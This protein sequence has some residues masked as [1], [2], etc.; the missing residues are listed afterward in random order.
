[1]GKCQYKEF[2]TI[3]GKFPY[4]INTTSRYK[5][6]SVLEG[7]LV[8]GG[9]FD[10]NNV[11]CTY[12][13]D[14]FL[15]NFNLKWNDLQN[16]FIASFGIEEYY[17][18]QFVLTQESKE[19]LENNPILEQWRQE[20]K[21]KE[22]EC[23]CIINTTYFSVNLNCEFY[24]QDKNLTNKELQ[25]R[26]KEIN[27]DGDVEDDMIHIATYHIEP[28]Q[29]DYLTS[30]FSPDPVVYPVFIPK[31]PLKK[32]PAPPKRRDDLNGNF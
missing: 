26:Y 1:M 5:E 24:Q 13:I 18:I 20:E 23:P 28:H 10:Y 19:E 32:A 16:K 12:I 25:R 21:K 15:V 22:E 11:K 29:V 27:P 9:Y 14:N 6:G 3:D 31:K 30:T 17:K 7:V 8:G 4:T 2:D